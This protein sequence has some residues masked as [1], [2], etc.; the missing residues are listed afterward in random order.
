MI[1]TITLDGRKFICMQ[2]LAANQDAYIIAHLRLASAIEVLHGTDGKERTDEKR[3]EDLLTQILLAGR[4]H[5]VLAGCLTEEGKAWSHAEA[6]AN[7]A[8]FGA[9]TDA[10]EKTEMR[11]LL[12]KFVIGLFAVREA[13]SEI[14]RSSAKVPGTKNAAPSTSGT[15][16]RSF[17]KSRAH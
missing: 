13:S 11:T 1:D 7:A 6:D 8:R 15:S 5:H 2:A 9:I 14:S 17:K 4:S 12:V 10:S 3:L 16:K